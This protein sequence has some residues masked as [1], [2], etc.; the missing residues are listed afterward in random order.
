MPDH[1]GHEGHEA[2]IILDPNPPLPVLGGG[3]IEQWHAATPVPTEGLPIFALDARDRPDLLALRGPP[4]PEDPLGAAASW[5]CIIW[6]E[7][8]RPVAHLLLTVRLEMPEPIVF[9]A[10]FG[11]KCSSLMA[12]AIL[13]GWLAL[14]FWASEQG[15]Q[16]EQEEYRDSGLL[17]QVCNPCL[18]AALRTMAGA[19]EGRGGN[20]APRGSWVN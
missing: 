6:E 9:T 11:K 5:G 19:I 3:L 14:T 17:V 4:R 16:E 2:N 20:Q 10:S 12:V 7:E 15:E 13:R 1:E 18:T 8:G